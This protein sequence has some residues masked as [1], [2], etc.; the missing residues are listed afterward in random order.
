MSLIETRILTEDTLIGFWKLEE[1]SSELLE[2]MKNKLDEEEIAAYKRFNHERRRCEWLA[3]RILI[4]ALLGHYPKIHYEESGKPYIDNG[5]NISITHSYEIVGVMVSKKKNI[6]VD[7]EKMNL[8]ILKIEH[9]FMD[10]SELDGLKPISRL[11]SLYVNWCAKEAMYK[12]FNINDFDFKDNFRLDPFD[13]KVNGETTG[14]I[15]Q[16]DLVKKFTIHYREFET[17]MVAWCAE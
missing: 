7:V 3:S 9:K 2:M 5:L 6:G 1:D 11:Q 17:Y 8:R 12:A 14:Q 4:T 16:G 13:Y 15:T 10:E